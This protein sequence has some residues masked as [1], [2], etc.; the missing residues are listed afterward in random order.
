MHE[1]AEGPEGFFDVDRGVGAVHLVQVDPVGAEAAEG[2]LDFLDDPPA[3]ATAVVG[4]LVHGHEELGG[5]ETSS[6]R[7]TRALP[8]ISSETPFE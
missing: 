6:R 4:V 3:R 1:V 5:Q 2:V 8:V 7:P